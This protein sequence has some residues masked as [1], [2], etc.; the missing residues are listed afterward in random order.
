MSDEQ[1]KGIRFGMSVIGLQIAVVVFML[2]LILAT[3]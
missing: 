2:T 3:N 1:Y